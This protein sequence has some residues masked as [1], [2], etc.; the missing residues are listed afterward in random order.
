MVAIEDIL[1]IVGISIGL[2]FVFFVL[3]KRKKRTSDYLFVIMNLLLVVQL[4][5]D[6]RWMEN[7]SALSFI[8]QNVLNFLY[9]PIFVWYSLTIIT[10]QERIDPKWWWVSSMAL[11]FVCFMLYDFLFWHGYE[12]GDLARICADPLPAYQFFYRAHSVFML[13]VLG[14]LWRKLNQYPVQMEDH[15]SDIEPF[16]LW[17]LR[18]FMLIYAVLTVLISAAYLAYHDG[19]LPS[20]EVPLKM[21]DMGLVVA[22]CYLTYHGVRYYAWLEKQTLPS[23][24]SANATGPSHIQS[25]STASKYQSSSLSQE[26]MEGIFQ[27]ITHLL[28]GEQLYL[29]PQLQ[30]NDLASRINVT[31]HKVSQTINSM[32]D[33]TFFELVN[34][35]RVAHLQDLL[36]SPEHKA[37]TILGLGLESGFNSKASLNRIFKRMTGLSPREYQKAHLAEEGLKVAS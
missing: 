2:F 13:A 15:F 21:L 5:A 11:G 35:Y 33:K 23:P 1:N 4:F 20:V 26:E 25:E 19:L 12:P 37:Y 3:N 22:L 18:V 31:T 32:A 10:R 30:V 34:G 24:V 36:I 29:E 28:E 9:F 8:A 6:T 27:Q 16:R 14:W 17:W 7:V